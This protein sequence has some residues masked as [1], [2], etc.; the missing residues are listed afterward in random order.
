MDKK[1]SKE[2]KERK[3]IQYLEDYDIENVVSEMLNSLLHEMDKHPYVYMIKYLASLMTEDERKEFDLIIPEPYPQSY[4]ICNY[5]KFD[6]LNKSLFKKYFTREKFNQLRKKKTKYGNNL[7]SISKISESLPSD[8][9]GC[10]L[11]D[12]DCLNV[13]KPIFDPIIEE[14]HDIK[15]KELKE[16]K[17]NNYN[18]VLNSDIG[19]I[20]LKGYIKKIHLSFSRN[21]QDY[22]F[23]NYSSGNDRIGNLTE[24]LNSEI[25]NKITEHIIPKLKKLTYKENKSEVEKILNTINYDLIWFHASG[26]KH[27]FPEHRIIYT[28]SDYSFVILLNFSDHFQIIR[29]MF[30]DDLNIE[31]EYENICEIIQQLGLT[32]PFESHKYFGYITTDL[33]MLGDG[34]KITAEIILKNTNKQILEGATFEE[35]INGLK[36]ER[37][38]IIKE[39]NDVKL[40]T[41]ESSKITEKNYSFLTLYLNKLAGLS[42]IFNNNKDGKKLSL[43]KIN[44]PNVD[45]P[46]FKYLKEAYNDTFDEV[47]YYISSTGSNINDFITPIKKGDIIEK[48]GLLFQSKSEI[49]AFQEFFYSYILKSQGFNCKTTEHIHEQETQKEMIELSNEEL[50]KVK[51]IDIIILRNIDGYPFSASSFNQNEQTEKIII[52]TINEMNSKQD[53]AKYYS[54]TK[55]KKQVDKILKENDLKLGHSE[56]LKESNLNLDYPKNRDL[57]V[58]EQENIFGFINDIAHLKIYLKIKN[59]DENL[60]HDFV[61]LLKIDNEFIKRIKYHYNP[62]LGFITSSIKYVGT[63][64][65]VNIII[66]VDNL[67]KKKIKDIVKGTGF[68]IDNEKQ[69]GKSLIFRLF[70][71][72]TIGQSETSLL[73]KLLF[74]MKK[75][76]DEDN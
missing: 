74:V 5:P 6:K 57:I 36:F 29:T 49:L 8:P 54:F 61:R 22:P 47:K 12:S 52:D 14:V 58:F 63:G 20:Q 34:F 11:S 15:I 62:Y 59:P 76:I 75:I 25:E 17:L 68:D 26:V 69:E 70:N 60:N 27:S 42:R 65:V 64:I 55:N 71:T 72:V 40:L 56:K 2:E 38:E 19:L 46:T 18:R 7:N 41:S 3:V 67:T 21:I 45:S 48:L 53:F 31:E 35:L 1:E 44:L 66:K 16:Y 9:I 23:N 50:K 24:F 13:Y 33:N 30:G 4:P 32:I 10:I 43:I 73:T 37:C 39:G 51:S 28:N